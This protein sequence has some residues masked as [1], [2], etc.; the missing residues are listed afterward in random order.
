MEIIYTNVKEKLN[1]AGLE[2]PALRIF[3]QR[4]KVIS[5][6]QWQPKG[7]IGFEKKRGFFSKEQCHV[8][9]ARSFI[10]IAD[11]V[12]ADVVVTPE[13]SFPWDLLKQILLGKSLDVQYGVLWCL[14][15]EGISYSDFTEF[16]NDCNKDSDV[17]VMT[18]DLKRVSRKSFLSC[19]AYV[20]YSSKKTVCIIQLKTTAASDKWGDLEASGLTT[21]NTIYYFDDNLGGNCLISII[22][23]DALN[24]SNTQFN[25]QLQYRKYLLLHPQLNPKPFHQSF[26]QM[27][28]YLMSFSSNNIRILTQNWSK[29]SILVD[30]GGNQIAKINDSYSA[31]YYSEIDKFEELYLKNKANGINLLKEDHV[32]IWHMPEKE[33]CI[34]YNIDAFD[35]N[36][37]NPAAGRH[38]EPLGVQYMEY[39][40]ESSSWNAY[41]GCIACSIDWE[42]LNRQFGFSAC[43]N[44]VCSVIGLHRFFSIL[45]AKEMY[46]DLVIEK[47]YSHIIFN[48]SQYDSDYVNK[49]RERCESINKVLELGNIPSKFSELKNKN[50][51]WILSENGNVQAKDGEN[52]TPISIIYIDSKAKS[53]IDKGI[54]KF[55]R[56][57]HKEF[58]ERMILYNWTDEGIKYNENIYN[59]EINNP[60]NVCSIADYRY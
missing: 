2:Y 47:D 25:R 44:G 40:D 21:G 31:C 14:G 5:I 12:N 10:E 18:E 51:Q 16:I 55:R 11:S 46:E 58:W 52:C 13:Y 48:E 28:N 57:V 27:R 4:G 7:I 32:F 8:D 41:S 36:G 26:K 49:K 30:N 34:I 33:H 42:W 50:Y 9:K 20:F 54:Q 56:T 43:N 39:D 6:A 17:V 22:C 19:L 59:K 38:K 3:E 53:I 15:M 37:V 24:Q 29:E 35:S 45:F 23:A 1:E 60:N